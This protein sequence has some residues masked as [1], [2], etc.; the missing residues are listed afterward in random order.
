MLFAADMLFF[1]LSRSYYLLFAGEFL[2]AVGM[3]LI[4]GADQAL[5]YDSLVAL[6]AEGRARFYFS[7]YEAAGTL[8]LLVAFPIGSWIAGLR[9]YPNLLPMPFALTTLS[10]VLAAGM[11][12]S[13][14]EPPR[15]K[16]KEH[17]F[18]MGMLGLRTL[19][20]HREL[21]AYVFN[22]ITISSVT[23]F[24]FW[25]YQPVMQRAGLGVTYLGFIGAGFNLF[26]AILLANVSILEK[27]IGVRRLLLL[28]AFVPAI[29]FIALGFTRLL[30]FAIPA[31]FILVGCKMV[32]IPILNALINRHVESENRATVISS[33]SL[34]ERFVTF[35][36][37]P[38]VGQLADLSLNYALWLLGGVCLAFAS[39][40]TP[41]RP[42][43][44]RRL[45]E[46]KDQWPVIRAKGCK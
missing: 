27:A 30:A 4:S 35:L 20:A 39:R 21:R 37:Y 42:A 41:Q 6:K 8:G 9:N 15:A 38:I 25:F 2:G 7:R 11:F 14:R 16:P 34:L 24:A 3:T 31:L 10:A 22:A 26:S 17:F 28:T 29:L 5:L 32:R 45:G 40:D 19:F 1:G 36:L 18:K 44:D 33:V 43:S 13:M 23:F 46:F 12:S